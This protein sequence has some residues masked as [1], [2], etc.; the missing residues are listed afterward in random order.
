[1]SNL[2]SAIERA[3]DAFARE[4]IGAVKGAT[5]QELLAMREVAAA[6]PGRKRGR[7]P[8]VK[9]GRKA[10]RPAKANRPAARTISLT[11]VYATVAG[12]STSLA[13]NTDAVRRTL[14]AVW[15]FA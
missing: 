9:P 13:A 15:V 14:N 4:I 8:K 1:M 12:I 7:P 2:Q 10:G 6:A 3:A 5:L 11:T